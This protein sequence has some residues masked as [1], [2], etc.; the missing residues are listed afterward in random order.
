MK[1]VNSE[2]IFKLPKIIDP[3][4]TL[5]FFENSNEFSFEIK[6]V[7]WQYDVPGGKIMQGYAH[8]FQKEIIIALSGSFDVVIKNPLGKE[9]KITLNRSYHALYLPQCTWRH[10]ENFSTNSLAFHLV[11]GFFNADE[12]IRDIEQYQ[13]F[14]K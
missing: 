14:T 1:S 4:G 13:N 3:R 12:Y 11:N 6:R 7:F 9:N 8:K 2:I 10:L 5:S